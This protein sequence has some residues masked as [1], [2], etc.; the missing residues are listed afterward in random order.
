MYSRLTARCCTASPLQPAVATLALS[1][2]LRRPCV[3]AG[4]A[5]SLYALSS[6]LRW[7]HSTGSKSGDDLSTRLNDLMDAFGEAR[8]LTKDAMESVGT[9]YFADDMEDAEA[10]T[11]EVLKRWAELQAD[12]EKAGQTEELRKLRNMHDL[13]MKQMEAELETVRDAGGSG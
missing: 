12:L 11:K 8:E 1:T 7:Q 4:A 2:V 5:S 6:A 13:K 10:Q 3:T 9:T